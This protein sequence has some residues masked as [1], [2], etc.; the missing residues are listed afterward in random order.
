M[1]SS[2]SNQQSEPP[3]EIQDSLIS[4]NAIKLMMNPEILPGP[5]KILFIRIK[6]FPIVGQKLV[7]NT[8]LQTRNYSLIFH[9]VW[10][11]RKKQE[12]W[13]LLVNSIPNYIKTINVQ[14]T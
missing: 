12:K 6:V 9:T 11:K 10:S 1:D 4:S 2:P 14:A 3:K 5:S 7:L 8:S 13:G